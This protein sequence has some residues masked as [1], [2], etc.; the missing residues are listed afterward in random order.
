M[1]PLVGTRHAAAIDSIADT[2]ANLTGARLSEK[3]PSAECCQFCD[4][5]LEVH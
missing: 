3:D 2:W 4:L 5:E 1:V